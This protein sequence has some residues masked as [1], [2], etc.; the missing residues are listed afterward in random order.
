MTKKCL[1]NVSITYNYV[2]TL[3]ITHIHMR[4]MLSIW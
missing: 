2:N 1:I 3:G 4:L